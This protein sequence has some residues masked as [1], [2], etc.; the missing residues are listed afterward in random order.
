VAGISNYNLLQN[1]MIGD[2]EEFANFL[3]EKPYVMT[4][5]W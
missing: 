5:K 3:L 2:G 1:K 4:K